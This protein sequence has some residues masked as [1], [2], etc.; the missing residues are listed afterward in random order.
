MRIIFVNNVFLSG[1]TTHFPEHSLNNVSPNG[2]LVVL[3][4][5]T[6]FSVLASSLYF[7][8]DS[9][10]LP[11]VQLHAAK[12]LPLLKNKPCPFLCFQR[13]ILVTSYAYDD[14]LDYHSGLTSAGCQTP[15]WL[16]S[17]SSPL[18]GQ[19]QKIR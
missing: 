5:D 19:A 6:I 12:A 18:T 16:F 13:S 7:S 10:S 15:T 8:L 17:H 3:C 4:L 11:K 14:F 2:L 1:V 9:S